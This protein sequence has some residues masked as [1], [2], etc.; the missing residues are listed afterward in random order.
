MKR[1]LSFVLAMII[2]ICGISF[3]D[4][5]EVKA[6][7]LK[8]IYEIGTY[9]NSN[10]YLGGNLEVKMIF[11][12][13][14]MELIKNPDLSNY[15]ILWEKYNKN[16][17]SWEYY[18][19]NKNLIIK[20]A[21]KDDFTNYK[22]TLTN[23]NT[24][25]YSPSL[26][27]EIKEISKNQ[28][29]KE[30]PTEEPTTEHKSELKDFNYNCR[31]SGLKNNY[32]Y[33]GKEIKPSI[34]VYSENLNGTKA[35]TK[36]DP[37]YY[38]VTYKNNIK[39]GKASITIKGKTP[40]YGSKTIT[41]KIKAISPKLSKVQVKNKKKIKITCKKVK[42]DG[43]QFR[44]KKST[45]KLNKSASKKGWKT[46]TSKKNI[47]ITK[48]LKKGN[49][50]VQ[51]RSYVKNGNK[52]IYSS[53][54]S[55]DQMT[56][57]GKST[58]IEKSRFYVKASFNGKECICYAPKYA[59]KKIKEKYTWGWVRSTNALREK[60]SPYMTKYIRWKIASKDGNK[61]LYNCLADVK[62]NIIEEKY[63]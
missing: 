40:Y 25:G 63:Y 11:L 50:F 7:E 60:T 44:Y 38:T 5:K 30:N 3:G 59:S 23:K 27:L 55:R 61:L 46:K 42:C 28:Y 26:T 32:N 47:F 48:K 17:K 41:F 9:D 58:K 43:Y 8:N 13:E 19:N 51:V 34:Q 14:N 4:Y 21:K 62:G 2:A 29:E 12:D 52:K 35:E 54:T 36:L 10:I 1:I 39:P 6:T 22:I 24:D 53:Y 20:N 57:V 33:I 49:Y 56:V 15:T 37:K 18:S 45:Q 31:I 16:K